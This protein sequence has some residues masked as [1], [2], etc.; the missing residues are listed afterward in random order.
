MVINMM[1]M[2][3]KK[4]D[5]QGRQGHI[6]R[7]KSSTYEGAWNGLHEQFLV[8]TVTKCHTGVPS[9]KN[10][11]HITMVAHTELVSADDL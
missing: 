1:M 10:I 11:I 4:A 7:Q 6:G 2:D 9:F 8:A 3:I 5:R